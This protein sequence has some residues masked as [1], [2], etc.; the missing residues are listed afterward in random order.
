[1]EQAKA[2]AG[3]VKV[4]YDAETP[5]VSLDLSD[6][7]T[8]KHAGRE[9]A[10]RCGCGV[11]GAPVKIDQTYVTPVETHNPIELHATVAAWDGEQVTS[12]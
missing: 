1:M 6:G 5:N 12:L 2:A 3:A 11:P 7:F 8:D 4:E 10:R 9:Q